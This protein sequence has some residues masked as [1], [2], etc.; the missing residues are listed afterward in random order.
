MRISLD[1]GYQ[2]QATDAGR[3]TEN[4][5]PVGW[6]IGNFSRHLTTRGQTLEFTTCENYWIFEKLKT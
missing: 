5:K 2:L 3:N 4:M 6:N 1:I